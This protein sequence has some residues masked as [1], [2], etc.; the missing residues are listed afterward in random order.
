MKNALLPFLLV[1][2]L[3]VHAQ[4]S[5]NP[6]INNW[7]DSVFK[8]LTDSQKIAQ[9]IVVRLSSIDPGTGKITF[10]DQ[11]VE[12]DIQRFNVGGICLFQGGPKQ[13]AAFINH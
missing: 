8:T 13:Q 5:V 12:S 3:S 1:F 2:S 4:Y 6:P 9:L 10:Y 11:Q 7:V